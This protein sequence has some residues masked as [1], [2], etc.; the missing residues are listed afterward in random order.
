MSAGPEK[1][2]EPQERWMVGNI[3]YPT[4]GTIKLKENFLLLTKLIKIT[5][6]VLI[7]RRR[8][9][10]CSSTGCG[11]A[12]IQMTLFL[13]QS[14]TLP[15]LSND[16]GYTLLTGGKPICG[17]SEPDIDNTLEGTADSANTICSIL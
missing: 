11:I 14:P 13:G 15:T 1:Q 6:K 3:M 5:V 16:S 12:S 4:N 7:T 8:S 2:M 9:T 10:F 17:E